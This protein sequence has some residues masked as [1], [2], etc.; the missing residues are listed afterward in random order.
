MLDV[1]Q[2]VEV[3]LKLILLVPVGPT[4]LLWLKALD[5]LRNGLQDEVD[6]LNDVR[7]GVCFA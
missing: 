7:L 4:R 2:V 1:S 5:V 3:E 6:E